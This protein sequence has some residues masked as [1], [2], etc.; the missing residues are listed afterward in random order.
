MR[1]L[2]EQS[3]ELEQPSFEFVPQL[4]D[5]PK[6]AQPIP[7]EIEAVDDLH[8][9]AHRGDARKMHLLYRDILEFVPLAGVAHLA[10]QADNFAIHFDIGSSERPGY[11]AVRVIVRSLADVE[12]HLAE[13]QFEYERQKGLAPGEET[14]VLQDPDGN[15]LEIREHREI[16]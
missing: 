11:R 15:W 14:L 16:I 3:L 1:Q 6:M 4:D 13:A 5:R 10:Y 12:R 7:V 9:P 2:Q 8:L